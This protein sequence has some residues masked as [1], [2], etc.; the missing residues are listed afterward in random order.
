MLHKVLVVD[1]D[2]A[3]RL[4]VKKSLQ[5]D[6]YQMTLCSDGTEA[7]EVLE[8]QKFDLVLT[9]LVME[10]VGGLELLA[11][12]REYDSETAVVLLT[13]HASIETAI[14]AVRLGASD[15]LL[16]PVNVEELRVRVK[17]ALERVELE[18]RLKEAERNLTYSATIAT[19][20]HEINQP[21]TVIIS[22]VDML[23]MELEKHKIQNTRVMNYLTLMNKSANRIAE[24]LRKLREIN[25]PK[26]QEIP[27]GMKMIDFQVENTELATEDQYI[28]VVE[29]EENLR[30][31][32]SRIL[33]SVGYKV[34]LAGN[35]REALEIFQHHKDV[36]ELVLLDIYLPDQSGL[37]LFTRFRQLQPDL[38]VLLTSGFEVEESVE[39][40]MREGALGFIRK[41][42]NRQQILGMIAKALKLQP[43]TRE[44]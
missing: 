17:R 6:G 21:L 23:R 14:D 8:R 35:A 15:Y 7:L 36:I 33:E 37:E 2:Y 26:I 10:S 18:R 4:M 38:K 11:K 30:Q 32:L 12:V 29:D 24:I 9:D 27:L 39:K 44:A 40:L 41:P 16:K 13:G 25:S 43:S 42:F 3:T 5:Q 31:I 22:A 28:L 34:F 20:N 19:A 1:D